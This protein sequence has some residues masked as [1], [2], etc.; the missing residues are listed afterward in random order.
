MPLN[1]RSKPRPR[2]SA[3]RPPREAVH[4][5]ANVAVTIGW[6]VLWFVAAVA[7]PMRLGDGGGRAAERRRVLEVEALGDE[8]RAEPE[9]LGLAHLVE[10]VARRVGVPRQRVEAELVQSLHRSTRLLE[11]AAL[12][13]ATP[14]CSNSAL[15]RPS[16]SKTARVWSPGSDG[17]DGSTAA[18]REKR[19]AGAGC[20]TPS[21][22]M[23]VPRAATVRMVRRLGHSEHR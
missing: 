12:W 23:K 4:R 14:A 19:G 20:T 3:N 22:V 1:I 2:P 8:R 18:V 17:D 21:T 9:R 15:S 7:M 11:S 16:S 10:Q 6:R 13:R 5:G